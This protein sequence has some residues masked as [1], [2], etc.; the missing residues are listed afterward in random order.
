MLPTKAWIYSLLSSDPALTALIGAGQVKDYEPE[1]K[2][3]F[4]IVILVKADESDALYSDNL[5]GASEIDYSIEVYT[6]A[7]AG[8]PT[9][10][11]IGMAVAAIL[12]PL[13][14][15]G[16]SRDVPDSQ[17]FIRHLHME[18]RRTVVAGD[19]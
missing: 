12:R 18:F 4:P 5:P 16:K 3:T 19:L 14:F 17:E 1:E 13:L 6:K 8:M 7:D 9:T 2:T 11:Q 10:T 15:S